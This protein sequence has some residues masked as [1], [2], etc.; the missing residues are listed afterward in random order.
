MPP[1]GELG[2]TLA[3]LLDSCTQRVGGLL[4]I[5]FKDV[6]VELEQVLLRVLDEKNAKAHARARASMRPRRFRKASSSGFTRPAATLWAL[7]ARIFSKARLSW[8][9]S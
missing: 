4:R 9:C 2:E 3:R 6:E 8:V 1:E 5:G 7:K